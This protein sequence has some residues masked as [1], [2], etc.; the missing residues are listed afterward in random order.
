[1][2]QISGH[3]HI[4]LFWTGLKHRT[5]Q[6]TDQKAD[7]DKL[8][9]QGLERNLDQLC[10]QLARLFFAAGCEPSSGRYFM[11]KPLLTEACSDASDVEIILITWDLP[12]L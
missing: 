12:M 9:I 3:D 7:C 5:D 8:Q 11:D 6:E 4:K 2:A 1:M 10:M